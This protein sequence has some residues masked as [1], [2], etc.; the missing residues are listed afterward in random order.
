MN[1]D[2]DVRD[3]V[4][5]DLN[6]VQKPARYTGGEYGVVRK[7]P[8]RVRARIALA[9][10]DVY[11][12]GMSH[13]GSHILYHQVNR[14]PEAQAERVYLPWPDM[15]KIL[16][17]KGIPLY[18]LENGLPVSG[19]DILGITLQYELTYS[20]VLRLL[21]LSGIPLTFSQREE[22]AA[23][24]EA[25]PLVVVGGPG[26]FNP[27]PLAEFVDVVALGDGEV[28]VGDL[29]DQL[30]QLD[31]EAGPLER[32][33]ALLEGLSARDGFY[34]PSGYTVSYGP[35]GTVE[36]V[37]AVG[38]APD[39]VTRRVASHLKSDD[40][41]VCPP[42]P[43]IDVVHDRGMVE[44]FRGCTRGCRFC[45][46]GMVYRPVRE[47]PAQE[48]VRLAEETARR[49]G[50]DEVSLVSLSSCDYTAL[51]QVVDE[52]RPRLAAGGV[53][54]SL[55]SL[56]VDSF[57]VELAQNLG[58]VRRTGLT[59]APEAGTQRL[60]DIIN[61]NVS[62]EEFQRALVSA[63]AAGWDTVKLYFMIGLPG[64]SDSDIEGIADMVK[65]CFS[66]YETATSGKRRPLKVNVSLAGFVPKPHTPF[67]WVAQA[68]PEVLEQRARRVQRSLSGFRVKVSY[69]D[70]R[71]SLLEAVFSRGDRRLGPVLLE[72]F[73]R[74]ARFDAWTEHFSFSTWE[75]AFK[76]QEV[77]MS[78]YAHRE[79]T[80]DEVLPWEHIDAGVKKEFLYRE[81][82]R[83]LEG[84]SSTD[85]RWGSCPDCGAC[86]LPDLEM[87]LSGE[88]EG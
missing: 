20:G 83:A 13:L 67:Q 24:G 34:L 28:L 75:A 76:Q 85:C 60:R 55:P 58:Q 15:E 21:D 52:L 25:F 80:P 56:R 68:P 2:T 63:F 30:L 39:K 29:V 74:G 59:L 31:P 77:D 65:E 87:R 44:L 5:F 40:Y 37:E 57:S 7:D 51:P 1:Q 4:F 64:E 26:A 73:R 82:Q 42:V 18:S 35:G 10:P 66:L 19:F 17:D 50:Y 81:Y 8:G 61:K 32:R 43:Y 70:P 47:R 36:S 14:R 72:A 33:R 86:L 78:F 69:T 6:Q 79:R 54:L 71:A 12:V 3:Q 11:E 45:Q 22:R 23:R 49:T 46:A 9:Y 48:T 53:G 88:G 84:R 41:P 16:R 27:E 62:H 38:G